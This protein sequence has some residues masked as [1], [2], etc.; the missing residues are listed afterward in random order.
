[1]KD[2]YPKIRSFCLKLVF[3]VISLPCLYFLCAFTLPCIPVNE[4]QQVVNDSVP[5]FVISNGVHTDIAVPSRST[6]KNWENTFCRD[7]FG[8]KDLSYSY[9]AFGWGDKGF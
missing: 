8:V 3:L 7:S 4:K 1:M 6:L 2:H 5:I 9:I